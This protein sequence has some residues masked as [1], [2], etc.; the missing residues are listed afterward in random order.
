MK[1][2]LPTS[3]IAAAALGMMVAGTVTIPAYAAGCPEGA[4]C[5]DEVPGSYND[6]GPY[7]FDSY[8]LSSRQTPGG[9]TVYY[10]TNT[11]PPYSA[12]VFCPPYTGTQVMYRDW[13]PFFASHGIVLV[14]MDTKSTGDSV[15]SRAEQLQEVLDTLKGEN[16]RDGSPLKGKLDTNRLGATGWSMGGG[17]TW[18]TSAEY[19][20]LKTA[21]TLA[22]HNITATGRDAKGGNTRIPTL[23]MNGATDNTILGGMEQ[24]SGVYNSIPS[25]VPKVLYEVSNAGHFDWGGPTDAFAAGE[26]ALAFQKTFLDGDTRWADYIKRP[27][28]NVAA[29]KSANLPNPGNTSNADSENT[30]GNNTSPIDPACR[31]WFCR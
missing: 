7:R 28:R 21:M 13:G 29:Y 23:I 25:G 31:W 17:A 10:P 8:T 11:P 2:T 18:I 26:L 27:N 30:T 9:A 15:D 12:M 3:Y 4:I 1:I 6:N 22:G 14:T 5:R 24:S 20:G 19:S 16:D